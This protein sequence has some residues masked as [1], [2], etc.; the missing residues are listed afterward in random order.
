MENK[1]N[2][3]PQ[4]SWL[5]WGASVVSPLWALGQAGWDK[6]TNK[7]K[8]CPRPSSPSSSKSATR[9][10][11]GLS[12]ALA[13]PRPCHRGAA[14]NLENR[15]AIGSLINVK[16]CHSLVPATAS[17]C[18]PICAPAGGVV[19]AYAC[20][21]TVV[22]AAI[23]ATVDARNASRCQRMANSGVGSINCQ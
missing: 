19:D 2:A 10:S 21:R 13:L 14:H 7:Q 23:N 20:C 15:I 4:R 16:I 3:L 18:V 5:N 12:Y 22:C 8:G 17:A 1:V 9:L 11:V 6:Q